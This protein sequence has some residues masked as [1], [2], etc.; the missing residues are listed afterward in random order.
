MK[1]IIAVLIYIEKLKNKYLQYK[2]KRNIDK[3][4]D[5]VYIKLITFHIK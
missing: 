2:N 1:K 3:G 5:D 4:F